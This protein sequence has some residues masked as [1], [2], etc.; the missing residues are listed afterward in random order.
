MTQRTALIIAAALTA[1]VLALMG[2]VAS[3]V[4]SQAQ[5]PT[6]QVPPA[7]EQVLADQASV[8]AAAAGLD[9]V[10]V[11]AA[12]QDRDAAYQQRIQAANQQLQQAYDK[13]RELA[14]QLNEAYQREQRLAG[15]LK[16]ARQQPAQPAAQPHQPAAQAEAAPAQPTFAV[17]PEVAAEIAL[18]AAPRATLVRLPDL[19]NFQGAVAYE[20]VLDSGSV[21]VDANSGQ[22]LYNGAIATVASGGSREHEGGEHEGGEHEGGEH[23]G[24]EHD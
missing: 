15:A 16:Q 22:V 19:V 10:A 1:F 9:P 2:G 18:G 12:I 8:P 17:T 6:A 20:V 24:G 3:Y 11:Q 23:E 7:G 4:T 5:G 21:Y 13:Q 14:A